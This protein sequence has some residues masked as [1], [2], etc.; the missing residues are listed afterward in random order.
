MGR[1]NRKNKVAESADALSALANTIFALVFLYSMLHSLL[2]SVLNRAGPV[3][4]LS[5]KRDCHS[6]I[7]G[8][9][10]AHSKRI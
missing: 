10:Q 4:F 5:G 7:P 9:E 1:A 3:L 6:D 8:W 2:S